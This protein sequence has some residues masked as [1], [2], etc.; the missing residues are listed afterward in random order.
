MVMM[1][2]IPEA[3][4]ERCARCPRRHDCPA[5]DRFA[6]WLPAAARPPAQR[7]FSA[8]SAG[9]NT[10]RRPRSGMNEQR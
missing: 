3:A 8:V 1:P 9:R 10:A 5:A 4:Q 7:R 6:A 2:D